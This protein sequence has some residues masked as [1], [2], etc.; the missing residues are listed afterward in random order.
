MIA[1]VVACGLVLTC[2]AFRVARSGK[3]YGPDAKVSRIATQCG[4]DDLAILTNATR[5]QAVKLHRRNAV[6]SV[7]RH[8]LPVAFVKKYRGDDLHAGRFSSSRARTRY[9]DEREALRK[10]APFDVAPRLVGY[11]DS[12]RCIATTH[13]GSPVPTRL[14]FSEGEV[15]RVRYIL[16]VLSAASILHED[17]RRSQERRRR[18]SNAALLVCAPSSA[19]SGCL[20]FAVPD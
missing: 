2:A 13:V 12:S 4:L 11:N 19:W 6:W 9:S 20:P 18:D 7:E 15:D 14:P 8:G 1:Q 5:V 17:V 10:L 3:P 16:R